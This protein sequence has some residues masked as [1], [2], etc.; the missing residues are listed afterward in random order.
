MRLDQNARD[1]FVHGRAP[2]GWRKSRRSGASGSCVEAA[3][4]PDSVAVRDSK[5]R[6][7][8][9]L[10]FGPRTWSG[11]VDNVKKDVLGAST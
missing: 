6:H 4:S 3:P 7:G 5:D 2:T 8:P 1:T 10:A 9:A 11:F